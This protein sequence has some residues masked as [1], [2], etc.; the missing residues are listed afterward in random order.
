MEIISLIDLTISIFSF[1]KTTLLLI[2]FASP[3]AKHGPPTADTLTS[4]I[5]LFLRI[6]LNFSTK[7]SNLLFITVSPFVNKR[8]DDEELKFFDISFPAHSI[9][10]ELT[11]ITIKSGFFLFH[12]GIFQI[13]QLLNFLVVCN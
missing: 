1:A 9:P 8:I 4:S 6:N 3:E 11:P 7:V 12:L 5:P 10:F 13:F 2:L